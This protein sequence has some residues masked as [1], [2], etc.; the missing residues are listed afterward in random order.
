MNN[1]II[2]RNRGIHYANVFTARQDEMITAAGLR[3]ATA[4]VPF[5]LS[6]YALKDDY[7]DPCDGT[8]LTQ[9]DVSG[10]SAG[11]H[12]ISLD[13]VC[14][15]SAG[16]HFS[17]VVE[18][19]IQKYYEFDYDTGRIGE[20]NTYVALYSEDTE[21]QWV[22]ATK[23]TI[24]KMGNVCLKLY[25]KNSNEPTLRGD[26]NLDGRVNAVD[27]SLLKQVLL[28][29]ERTDIDRKADDWNGDSVINAEDA[30]GLLNYLLTASEQEGVKI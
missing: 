26:L 29:S 20:R 16:Q 19:C 1:C 4:N 30:H 6:V 14:Q 25:S 8:L 27:L 13:K 15:V 22:D 17:A 11:Y 21:P 10:L 9:F 12:T 28:S 7:K 2:L 24:F 3:T 5:R 23:S 18:V